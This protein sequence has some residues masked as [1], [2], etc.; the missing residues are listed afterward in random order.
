VI[1]DSWLTPPEFADLLVK[2]AGGPVALD[3]CAARG[4]FVQ[5]KRRIYAPRAGGSGGG[6][7]AD[8][9]KVGGLVFVNPPWNS[10]RNLSD[11]SLK[12][13][14]EVM[15]ARQGGNGNFSV[16]ALLPGNTDTRWY[17]SLF[18]FAD[19]VL[20]WRGRMC[21]RRAGDSAAN[22]CRFPSHVFYFGQRGGRSPWAVQ[23]ARLSEVFDDRGVWLR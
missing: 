16:I 7:V 6:L 12:I 14:S 8:W 1:S 13:W 3:P 9:S 4:Q 18:P 23:S 5:A 15:T 17:Q 19:A 21:F 2:F 10:A 22:P 11:W 20:A